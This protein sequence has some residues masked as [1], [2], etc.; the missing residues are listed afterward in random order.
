MSQLKQSGRESAFFLLPSVY[1]IQSLNR[2]DETRPHE[3][4][5][6]ALLSLWIQMLMSS[7]NTLTDAPEM[8][9]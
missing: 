8:F 6:S 9:N 5:E 1:S 3:R 2:L 4:G 7:G